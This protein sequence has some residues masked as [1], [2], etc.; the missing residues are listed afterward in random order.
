VKRT[1]LLILAAVALTAGDAIPD[2]AAA[3]AL[4]GARFDRPLWVGAIPGTGRML[5]LEQGGR[6][7]AVAADGTTTPFLDLTAAVALPGGY[8]EEGLL[9][10]VFHP[11]FAEN[12]RC[13]VWYTTRQGGRL[14]TVLAEWRAAA[15]GLAVVAG[16]E[17]VLLAIPQ[18]F[19]NHN[20][21]DLHFGADGMLYLAVGDGGSGGD[22]QNHAQR[23]DSLLG[24]VLRLDVDRRDGANPYAVPPDN[25]FIGRAG[26]RPEIWA[27]GLR[28]VWRMAFDRTTGE[29]WA[30][31]VGQNAWEE[32]TLI[33]RGGNHGW[34]LREGF[35]PFKGGERQDGM[36]EPVWAYGRGDGKSVTG[37]LVY[38]GAAM[39]ALQG[40]YLFGDWQSRRIWGLRRGADGKPTVRQVGTAPGQLASF[41]TDAAGEPL[42]ACFDGRIYALSMR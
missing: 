34:R 20:G 21:G 14:R 7:L 6:A 12:R 26:A 5:V 39:P 16:S 33:V 13:F 22:P 28:N 23:L 29:L 3:P 19:A 37:G 40:V 4:G 35:E 41:G 30:G 42:I 24:K 2:L 8:T 38:R 11:R 1:L 15:D 10:L 27:Y 36:V 25:P 9:A 17:Q 32:I 31:D 18:P